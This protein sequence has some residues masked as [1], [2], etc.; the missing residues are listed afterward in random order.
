RSLLV[1]LPWSSV[2]VLLA[3]VGAAAGGWRLAVLGSGC[4]LYIAFTGFWAATMA[5]L[6][7]L[8]IIVPVSIIFGFGI[9]LAGFYVPCTRRTM[10]ATLDLMQTIPAFSYLLPF[11]VMFGAG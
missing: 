4:F 3:A 10:M 9:G 8:V 1:W 11:L 6:A 7:A 2:V 5:T